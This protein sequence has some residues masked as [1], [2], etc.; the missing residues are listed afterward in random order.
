MGLSSATDFE[1]KDEFQFAIISNPRLGGRTGRGEGPAVGKDMAADALRQAVSALNSITPRPKM[2][3]M[4]GELVAAAPA[5]EEEHAAQTSA[6]RDILRELDG[7]VPVVFVPQR[8][9]KPPDDDGRCSYGDAHFSFWCAHTNTLSC[10]QR[11][12]G[13]TVLADCCAS[14]LLGVN[15]LVTV[16][17]AGLGAAMR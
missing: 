1:F 7:R 4:M 3:V 14:A 17:D 5:A 9:S 6:L 2:V 15:R 8:Y 16:A 13:R 12:T 11:A 10:R